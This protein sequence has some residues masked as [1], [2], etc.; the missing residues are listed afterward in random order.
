MGRVNTRVKEKETKHRSGYVMTERL[1]SVQKYKQKG[2][3]L[4]QRLVQICLVMVKQLQRKK[5]I[6]MYNKQLT[7][8]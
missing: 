7:K 5:W 4:V 1:T 6:K 3:Y 2:L 8:I